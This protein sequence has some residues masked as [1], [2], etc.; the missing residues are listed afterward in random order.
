[1]LYRITDT[2]ILERNNMNTPTIIHAREL[3]DFL[4]GLDR[5]KAGVFAMF[6]GGS[7]KTISLNADIYQ[8]LD[9]AVIPPSAIAVGVETVGWAAP[10]NPDN[11]IGDV[12]PSEHPDR[13]RVHMVYVINDEGKASIREITRPDGVE[14]VEDYG[15][16]SG[17]LALAVEQ[18]WENRVR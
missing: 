1:L 16:A 15:N 18:M 11:E 6:D 13:V 7:I 4:D 9:S 5:S 3:L 2:Y 10:L 12:P 14:I 17:S 8:A